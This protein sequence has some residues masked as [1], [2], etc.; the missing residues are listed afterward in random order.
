MQG[1][2]EVRICFD[3]SASSD[4]RQPGHNTVAWLHR[5]DSFGELALIKNA[6]RTASIVVPSSKTEVLSIHKGDFERILVGLYGASLNERAL[7]LRRLWTFAALPTRLVQQLATFTSVAIFQTGALF[8]TEKDNRLY[9]VVEGECRLCLLDE[10]EEN[11]QEPEVR[12]VTPVV[13]ENLTKVDDDTKQKK[14]KE[15]TDVGFYNAKTISRLGPGN[16]FGEGCIF[17][18][19]RRDW[20]VEAMTEVKLYFISRGDIMNNVDKRVIDIIR[21]EAEFKATYYDGR[22]DGREE[23]RPRTRK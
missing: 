21:R 15:S 22:F 10:E 6:P 11:Q 18:E 14:E 7:F 1:R 13:V 5:G 16:F 3:S 19:I 20:I 4:P 2:V 17:P 8:D 12:G 9:F 23:S